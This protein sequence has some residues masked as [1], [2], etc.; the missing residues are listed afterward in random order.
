V[1]PK[2]PKP[3]PTAASTTES[4]AKVIDAFLSRLAVA[5]VGESRLVDVKFTATD[6]AFAAKV[7]NQLADQY[8]EQGRDL[9]NQASQDALDWLTKK[10]DEQKNLMLRSEKSAQSYRAKNDPIVADDKQNIVMQKLADLNSAVT[11]AKTARIAKESQFHQLEAVRDKVS[12]LD[13]L[14]SVMANTFVQ[15]LKKQLADLQRQKAEVA[16]KLGEKNPRMVSLNAAIASTESRLNAEID[17][18]I[19]AVRNDYQAALA[20]EKNLSAALETQKREALDLQAKAID[21]G[22]YQRSASVDKE[23]FD[24][25]TQRL[26]EAGIAGNVKSSDIRIVDRAEIPTETKSQARGNLLMS[27]LFGLV[28]SIGLTFFLEYLDSTVKSPDE[29]REHLRLSFLGMLPAFPVDQLKGNLPLVTVGSPSHFVEAFQTVRT[30]VL[31]SATEEGPKTIM[32]TSTQPSEGKS[33]VSA[34]LAASLGQVGLTV[35]I[36]DAD[37]RRPSQHTSFGAKR[38]VGLSDV[39][40]GTAKLEDAVSETGAP[41]VSLMTAGGRVEHPAALLESATFRA[42][43]QRLEKHFDWVIVDS[44][45][46]LPVADAAI[47]AANVHGVLFVVGSEMTSRYAAMN[48]LN[49]LEQAKAGFVGAVLNRVEVVRHSYYY[50]NY[51][52]RKYSQYYQ[53]KA[54]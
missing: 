54:S 42:M 5:P 26:R 48:A 15:D 6:P 39:L 36:I 46:V 40:S 32:V 24:T 13:E 16:E 11:R 3:A 23:I 35:L 4:E 41:K 37:M 47:I 27:F 33:I 19:A 30:N 9:K 34:N 21:F 2:K 50:A 43:L 25:L 8:I 52:R 12:T 1:L 10:L 51:Y 14:P 49:Q 18:V 7:L 17:K 28:V 53:E 44:P 22:T 31:F 45:P 29:I 38:G 20:E